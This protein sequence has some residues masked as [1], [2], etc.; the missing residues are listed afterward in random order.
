MEDLKSILNPEQYRAATAPDG[1]TLVIA[2]AG[3][4]KTKTLVCRILHLLDRGVPPEA[5]LLLTF[6]NKAASEMMER[7]IASAGAQASRIWGGTFH[8][9][10][11]MLLRRHAPLVGYRESF[12][13]ADREDSRRLVAK[14][15]ADLKIDKDEVPK[16]DVIVSL[17]GSAVSMRSDVASE[18]ARRLPEF[19]MDMDKLLAVCSRYGEMKAAQSIMDFDDLLVN[20]LRLLK[21]CPDILERYRRRF[22]HILVDEYQDTNS[23][24]S[25]FVDLLAGETGSVMAVGDDFQCIYSWRGADVRNIMEFPERHPSAGIVTLERNYRSTP[26]ILAVANA[27]IKGNPE[28]FQKVLHATR[29]H[30]QKPVVYDVADGRAQAAAVA[31]TIQRC[32]RRGYKYSDIAVLYRSHYHSIELESVCR[33]F[34]MPVKIVSG[35]GFFESLHA[36]DF[37]SFLKILNNPE[38]YL[39]FERFIRLF[40][41]IGEKSAASLWRKSGGKVELHS[42]GARL[43]LLSM[44]PAKARPAFE[45]FSWSMAAVNAFGK[46][47][48]PKLAAVF[49]DD[50]YGHALSQ[51]EKA[52]EIRQDVEEVARLAAERNSLDDFFEEIALDSG[53]ETPDADH[54]GD[55]EEI[56]FSTIH[57]AKGLEWPVVIVLWLCEEMFPPSKSLQENRDDS[58]ERR[59]FYV[60]TTRA[61]EALYLFAPR[62]RNMFDGGG[63]YTR[64][65]RFVSELPKDLYRS[66]AFY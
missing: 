33:K 55:G 2:A 61:R 53:G 12:A 5:I 24:Q 10:S 8:H 17:M 16:K 51:S 65:S 46:E 36:K 64:V 15:I 63:Y 29:P 21:E 31:E 49:L 7:A 52:E 56:R 44:V 19:D 4:G 28:Q 47:C 3:T 14:A 66:T 57:Q 11:S 37:I 42:E 27:S 22:S 20:G 62:Y 45:G 38:D 34:R 43:A 60:A 50:V 9:I 26:E 23:L 13:I 40:P 25:E 6:T 39:S 59:L 41:G 30:G 48:L 58:E 54:G 1:K 32:L 35:L 18:V